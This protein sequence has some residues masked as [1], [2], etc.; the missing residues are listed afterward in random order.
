MSLRVCIF[1]DGEN[2]RH[3]ICDLFEHFRQEDYLPKSADWTRFFNR[4]AQMAENSGTR[5]RTYWYVIEHIDFFPYKFP[6][7]P[8]ELKKLLCKCDNFSSELKTLHDSG[9]E[10]RIIKI[11]EELLQ[12]RS[13]MLRRAEGWRTIQNEIATKHA[14]IEFRR[15]G[16]I[17]YNLFD[18]TF[19]TEKAVDVKLATDMIILRDIYDV[20]VIVSGDQDYVPAVEVI[21]DFGKKVVNV[22]FKTRGGKLLPGGARRLNQITDINLE[23]NYSELNEYLKVDTLSSDKNKNNP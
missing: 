5:L 22:S 21:K 6:K 13:T 1:V 18:K 19:G 10:N 9:L 14:C 15:A 16:G 12:Q 17:R 2:F 23:I 20:A 4:L 8:D 11:V 3:S 7:A